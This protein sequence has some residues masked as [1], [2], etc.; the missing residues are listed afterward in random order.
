MHHQEKTAVA[1]DKAQSRIRRE[2][3]SWVGPK[4]IDM[5]LRDIGSGKRGLSYVVHERIFV[6]L[7]ASQ[8]H[9]NLD[10]GIVLGDNGCQDPFQGRCWSV[11]D[12][13]HHDPWG[14]QPAG[15]G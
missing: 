9:Q 8:Q 2:S 10:I 12:N 6:N 13:G 15:V 11:N 5:G 7:G 1:L 3:E 14:A 4:L